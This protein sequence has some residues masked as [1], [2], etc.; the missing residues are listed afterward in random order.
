MKKQIL[1][2]LM[3]GAAYPAWCASAADELQP[4]TRLEG[5]NLQVEIPYAEADGGYLKL[6]EKVFTRSQ[7]A[8]GVIYE[9]GLNV[10]PDPQQAVKW[11]RLAAEQ[12]YASGQVHL[13][14]MYAR[15]T[16]VEQDYAQARKWYARA[17]EQGLSDA[18]VLLGEMYQNG[19]GVERDRMQAWAWFNTASA[20]DMNLPATEK[21]NQLG[22]KMTASQLQQAEALSSQYLKKYAP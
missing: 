11:Y 4:R 19:L 2:A 8:L 7:D 1:A 12:G 21:R 10:K 18:Q 16:G 13:G 9:L 3:M 22:S 20:N 6:T 14:R 5:V 15:G 17:A